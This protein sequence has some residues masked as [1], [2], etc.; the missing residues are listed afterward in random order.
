MGKGTVILN[1]KFLTVSKVNASPMISLLVMHFSSPE[2]KVQYLDKIS[3]IK[4]Y[5]RFFKKC[6]TSFKQTWHKD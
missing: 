5:P 3:A 4:C 2:V 1:A 6:F